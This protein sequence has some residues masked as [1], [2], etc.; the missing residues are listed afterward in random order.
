M[1]PGVA[2]STRNA[3]ISFSPVRAKTTK[4]SATVE[5]VI[6][7]LLPLIRKPL[8]SAVARVAIAAASEPVSGSVRAKAPSSSPPARRG[9]YRCFCSSVPNRFRMSCGRP[10]TERVPA[11]A[12]P[13]TASSSRTSA[14]VA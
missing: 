8:A 5:C 6:Q 10:W 13:A 2:F 3:E 14:Y 12:P 4:R 7:A 1:R 11:S 9:R